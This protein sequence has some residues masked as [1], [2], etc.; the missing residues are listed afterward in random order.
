ML[1]SPILFNTSIYVPPIDE[2]ARF[3]SEYIESTDVKTLLFTE[4]SHPPAAFSKF[5]LET[6]NTSDTLGNNGSLW[7]KFGCRGTNG[8]QPPE[9][10]N[11]SKARATLLFKQVYPELSMYYSNLSSKRTLYFTKIRYLHFRYSTTATDRNG[12]SSTAYSHSDSSNTHRCTDLV[13]FDDNLKKMMYVKP[14]LGDYENN[15][16]IPWY[17]DS[18][19]QPYDEYTITNYDRY[20]QYY[21]PRNNNVGGNTTLKCSME[22]FPY[23]NNISKNTFMVPLIESMYFNDGTAPSGTTDLGGSPEGSIF[24]YYSSLGRVAQHCFP[25]KIIFERYKEKGYVYWIEI[26]GL[27]VPSST[28]FPSKSINGYTSR[29]GTIGSSGQAYKVT[30]FIYYDDRVDQWFKRNPSEGSDA[31]MILPDTYKLP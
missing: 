4:G 29:S 7:G 31:E 27:S 2:Y 11:P 3:L 1:P 22:T 15:P 30:N 9:N 14:I 26:E 17:N 23:S 16:P 5:Q 19:A 12:I 6:D 28:T 20:F 10:N 21:R 18:A 13:F 25:E 8:T 24:S